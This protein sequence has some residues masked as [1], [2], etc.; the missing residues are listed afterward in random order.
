MRD[1]A[2]IRQISRMACVF[3][4]RAHIV[5]YDGCIFS[6]YMLSRRRNRLSM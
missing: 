6:L 5:W 2:E 1:R 3:W 4:H